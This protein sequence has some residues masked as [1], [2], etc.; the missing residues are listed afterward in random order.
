MGSLAVISAQA[1]DNDLVILNGRGMD[2]DSGLDTIR[3]LGK[4]VR[5]GGTINNLES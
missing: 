4:H 2:P 5:A 3:N 1:Q